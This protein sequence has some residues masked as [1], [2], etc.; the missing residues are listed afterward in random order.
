MIKTAIWLCL[1][2]FLAATLLIGQ[3]MYTSDLQQN[4]TRDIYNFTSQLVPPNNTCILMY[5]QTIT[6]PHTSIQR[7]NNIACATGTYAVVTGLEISKFGVEFGY[8][9]PEY[10]Y[11]F[12]LRIFKFWIYA[13]ILIAIIPVIIPL[14]ALVYLIGLGIYN[15][16]IKILS[17]FR[18]NPE[19]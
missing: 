6:F 10:D 19:D 13:L 3:A 4:T 2:I 8:L 18:R 16:V 14:C 7:L 9:H 15:L 5:N 17:C 1:F 11:N 12:F